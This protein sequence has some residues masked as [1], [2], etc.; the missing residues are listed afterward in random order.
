MYSSD[1]EFVEEDS[2]PFIEE[3]KRKCFSGFESESSLSFDSNYFNTLD[4]IQNHLSYDQKCSI[5]EEGKSMIGFDM[6]EKH[7]ISQK[8]NDNEGPTGTQYLSSKN[9]NSETF[10]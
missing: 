7:D 5:Y 8:E 10:T 6:I 4:K 9:Q 1:I 2:L 3:Q